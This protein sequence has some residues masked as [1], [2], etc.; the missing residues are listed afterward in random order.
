MRRGGSQARRGI[1][2][3]ATAMGSVFMLVSLAFE[4][5]NR[6]WRRLDTSV[7]S[8]RR[9]STESIDPYGTWYQVW[10]R[11]SR[12]QICYSS[13]YEYTSIY[14]VPWYLVWDTIVKF[15]VPV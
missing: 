5:S 3:R 13:I 14:E 7:G 15:T 1:I 2:G 8:E 6:N 12:S 9:C 10:A 11:T 4:I